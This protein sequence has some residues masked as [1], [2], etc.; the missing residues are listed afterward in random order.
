MMISRNSG[1]VSTQTLPIKDVIINANNLLN[2][3]RKWYNDQEKAAI[4][5]LINKYKD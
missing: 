5:N 3:G 2:L 4:F 1:D